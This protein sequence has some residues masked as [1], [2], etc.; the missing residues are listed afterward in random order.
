MNKQKQRVLYLSGPM[1][2]LPEHNFP[3]FDQATEVLVDTGFT[4]ISPADLDREFGYEGEY[5]PTKLEVESMLRRDIEAL[6]ECDGI[7]LLNG[8]LKSEG[9]RMEVTVAGSLNLDIYYYA[10]YE[11]FPLIKVSKTEIYTLLSDGSY[12]KY[13]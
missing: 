11:D 5:E 8:W 9:A 1:T 13:E 4:V 6:L 7:V 10:D 2:G 12:T 3:A